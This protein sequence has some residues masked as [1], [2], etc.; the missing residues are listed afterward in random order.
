MGERKSHK[1]LQRIFSSGF[2]ICYNLPA[3]FYYKKKKE[4][5]MAD[6]RAERLKAIDAAIAGVEKQFG[7]G[8]IMRLGE[9]KVEDV[10]VISTSCLSLDAALGIGGMP[11]G[12][13]IEIYGPEA[14]G[15]TTLALHV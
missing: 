5:Y 10:P 6:E 13:V 9:K 1:I 11:R 3:K 12:R 8:S 4:K 7:K 2:S 15:K 14:G